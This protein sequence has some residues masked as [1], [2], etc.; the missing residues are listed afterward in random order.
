MDFDLP[1][2]H[3]LLRRTV[4]DFATA[5]VAPVAEEL[6]RTKSFCASSVTSG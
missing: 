4:R 1:E 6:D 5:E 3:E 2:D